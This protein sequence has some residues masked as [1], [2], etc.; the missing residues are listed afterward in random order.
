MNHLAHFHLAGNQPDYIVG[1]LLGDH[2]KGLLR[3]ERPAAIE[4]GIRI[5]RRID[6]LTDTDPQVLAL[7][8]QL[9]PSLRRYGGIA[10]DVCF[11][12]CLSAHWQRWHPQPLPAFCKDV[13]GILQAQQEHLPAAAVTQYRRLQQFDVLINIRH[14]ETVDGILS[15]IGKRLRR[16]NPLHLAT[17]QLRPMAADI[18]L[19][20]DQFYPSLQRRLRDEF[21]EEYPL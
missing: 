2:V 14:W 19:A 8:T 6:A 7:L 5:H 9:P 17:E 11:D 4:T 15:A 10:L 13:Y 20:F 21:G 12:R 18:Q 3:G 1:A 16:D